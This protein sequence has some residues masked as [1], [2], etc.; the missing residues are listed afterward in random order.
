[1]LAISSKNFY[2]V[3]K[4]SLIFALFTPLN[5]LV[6]CFDSNFRRPELL[7]MKPKYSCES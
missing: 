1:M 2:I 6:F 7:E 5:M 4:K 3:G